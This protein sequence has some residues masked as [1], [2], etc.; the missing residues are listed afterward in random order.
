MQPLL[1]TYFG[2]TIVIM[3]GAHAVLIIISYLLPTVQEIEFGFAF[4]LNLFS[5]SIFVSTSSLNF[6]RIM[7]DCLPSV[8]ILFLMNTKIVLVNQG[9][10]FIREIGTLHAKMYGKTKSISALCEVIS[11]ER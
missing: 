3:R 11:G 10:F 4:V 1:K 9:V 7:C 6:L 2:Y 8:S 5:A